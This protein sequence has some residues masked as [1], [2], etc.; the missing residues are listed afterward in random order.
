MCW[1]AVRGFANIVRTSGEGNS[2]VAECDWCNGKD[3][4]QVSP[5]YLGLLLEEAESVINVVEIALEISILNLKKISDDPH[6]DRCIKSMS[7]ALEV[8]KRWHNSRNSR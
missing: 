8:I 1:G 2:Q 6:I 3:I 4:K 7:D 5:E